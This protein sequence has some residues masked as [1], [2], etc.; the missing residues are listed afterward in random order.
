M[1]FIGRVLG[2]LFFVVIGW[3]AGATLGFPGFVRDA[4]E[5][6]IDEDL[7][8]PALEEA[9]TDD[10]HTRLD[11][12]IGSTHFFAEFGAEHDAAYAHLEPNHDD[13]HPVALQPLD[14]GEDHVVAEAGARLEVCATNVSNAP[15]MDETRHVAGFGQDIAIDGVG[16]LIA[17]ATGA[18]LSSGFGPRGASGHFHKG[19]D[20]FAA[21]EGDV[22]AAAD[23]TV[24]E[25][26]YR[27]DYGY[28]V[29]ID[30]GGGVYTR[31]A[32]LQRFAAGLEPGL[33][34]ARGQVL[35]P[36]GQSGTHVAARHLH[37]EVLRGDYDNPKRSFGL[38]PVD[39][40]NV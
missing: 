32:H 4:V 35:G 24:L 5:Q 30:H 3:V 31:Y 17:P 36:I 33:A 26:V 11:L 6:M 16:L 22:I 2:A 25:A 23:G 21:G 28:M 19:L 27:N 9:Q 8:E 15:P 20:Y 39:P 12:H 38:E 13:S 29:V 1:D 10:G 14:E 37:Y 7:P 34:V 18:C 40:F